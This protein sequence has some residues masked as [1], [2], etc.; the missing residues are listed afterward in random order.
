MDGEAR[1]NDRPQGGSMNHE[2][3]GLETLLRQ[4]FLAAILQLLGNLVIGSLLLWYAANTLFVAYASHQGYAVT[5]HLWECALAYC[6]LRL[7]IFKEMFWVVALF[8]AGAFILSA[9]SH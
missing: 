2:R 6:V 8:A 9:I 5:I 3:D 1:Q 7:F 4:F